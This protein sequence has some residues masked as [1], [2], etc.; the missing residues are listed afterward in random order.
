[1]KTE[2]T[3]LVVSE[4][5]LGDQEPWLDFDELCERCSLSR[6][7]VEDLVDLGLVAPKSGNTENRSRWRFRSS[8]LVRVRRARRLQRELDL[9]WQGVAVTMDL[10]D[11]IQRLRHEVESLRKQ[12]GAFE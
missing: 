11:E 5:D 2:I 9:D 4:F 7:D 8:E 12:L 3:T 6:Q 1:M 10:L